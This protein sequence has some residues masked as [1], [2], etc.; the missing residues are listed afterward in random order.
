MVEVTPAMSVFGIL[1]RGFYDD[2]SVGIMASAGAL[3]TDLTVFE[4]GASSE[5]ALF[6]SSSASNCC[7]PYCQS[8][9]GTR[10]HRLD[11]ASLVP[12]TTEIDLY[13]EVQGDVG[14]RGPALLLKLACR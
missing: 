14:W 11:T 4:R 7:G 10:S 9:S 3:Q 5:A 1:P 6:V 8:Q 13:R 2:E 12:G